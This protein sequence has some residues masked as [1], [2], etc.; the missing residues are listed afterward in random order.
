MVRWMIIG[1]KSML[2]A[3]DVLHVMFHVIAEGL[4]VVP[5]HRCTTAQ[6]AFC[7]PLLSASFWVVV[8]LQ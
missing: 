2:H 6:F 7:G 4:A 3:V 5:D 1:R 8:G